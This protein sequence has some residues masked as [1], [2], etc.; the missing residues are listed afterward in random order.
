MIAPHHGRNRPVD[1]GRVHGDLADLTQVSTASGQPRDLFVL[2]TME[3]DVAVLFVAAYV[4]GAEVQRPGQVDYQAAGFLGLVEVAAHD[5]CTADPELPLRAGLVEF[6]PVL[7]D[8]RLHA[9]Q[10]STDGVCGLAF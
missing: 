9:P 7:H 4:P 8:L 5:L 2:V 6:D 10:R 1:A 3:H